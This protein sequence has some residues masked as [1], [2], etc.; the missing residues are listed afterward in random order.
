M[1]NRR[2]KQ[3][4]E[5]VKFSLRSGTRIGGGVHPSVIADELTRIHDENDG[6]TARVLVDESTHPTAP[7]HPVF[8]WD[9]AKAAD[10]YRL[11]QGRTLIRAVQ[12]SWGKSERSESLM[13]FVPPNATDLNPGAYHPLRIV[14]QH[15]DMFDRALRELTRHL[16]SA[17]ESVDKLEAA[18]SALSEE[19]RRSITATAAAI[20]AIV[21]DV[22][23]MEHPP[24]AYPVILPESR[25]PA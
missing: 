17:A 19:R 25:L 24:V 13:V 10:G 7:L 21:A 5:D 1:S 12:V 3:A 8:E 4:R 22:E 9:D 11:H 18:A 2:V 14:V 23:G 20:R 15:E 16:A 6:L